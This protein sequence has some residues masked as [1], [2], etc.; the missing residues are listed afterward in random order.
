MIMK[1]KRELDELH[2]IKQ[3]LEI[4]IISI[5]VHIIEFIY[6][7]QILCNKS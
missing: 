3:E 6:A 5:S 4:I 7:D 2:S 1:C